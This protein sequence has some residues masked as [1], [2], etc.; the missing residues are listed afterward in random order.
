M[1]KPLPINLIDFNIGV[2]K[3][4]PLTINGEKRSCPFC[5]VASLTDIIDTKEDMIFLKNKYRVLEPSDQFVLIEGADCNSDMNFYTTGKMTSLITFGISHWLKLWETGRYK[6]VLFF[7]NYGPLSGG[8]IHHPHMQIVGLPDIDPDLMFSA[9]EFEGISVATANDVEIN[10]ATRPRIGFSEINI[11]VKNKFS[12]ADIPNPQTAE[13]IATLAHYIQSSITFM[14][15]FFKRENFSYNI[16]FYL[17]NGCIRVKL[18]PRFA[19]SPLYIGYNIHLK[20]TNLADTAGK[21]RT[22]I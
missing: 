18:L 7:K 5:N 16:F 9:D 3:G 1:N 2:G 11:L 20:P 8:T 10:M 6:A 4:K 14:K 12:S 13:T 19:T 22:Y 17:L 21:L 15:D